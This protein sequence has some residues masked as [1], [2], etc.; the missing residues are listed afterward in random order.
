MCATTTTENSIQLF[1]LYSTNND[2]EAKSLGVFHAAKH[3]SSRDKRNYIL[4]FVELR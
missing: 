3:V 4:A 2:G 1:C